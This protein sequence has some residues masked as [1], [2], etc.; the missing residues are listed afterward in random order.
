MKQIKKAASVILLIVLMYI[1]APSL[2]LAANEGDN[3]Q[4][5]N[6]TNSV[7]NL[8]EDFEM[9]LE[10]YEVLRELSVDERNS[11]GSS[12][13]TQLQSMQILQNHLRSLSEGRLFTI[14]ARRRFEANL[15]I[16]SG[17]TQNTTLTE[18]IHGQANTP[19]NN[20]RISFAGNGADHGCGPIAVHNLLYSLYTAGIT[21]Q[22]PCIAEI[23]HRLEITG[24]FIMGGELGTNPLTIKQLL[25]ELGHGSHISFLPENIDRN[26]KKSTA[27]TAI[28]LYIGQT[29][30]DKAYWHYIM[31]RHENELFEL[32]NVGGRDRSFRTVLSVDEWT[33]SRIP[34]A[35]ITINYATHQ[36]E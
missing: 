12:M 26:I 9:I 19:Q 32:Y 10:F 30:S 35:L 8:I 16:S 2:V 17:E 33:K 20:L 13:M 21:D 31:I 18:F 5:E 28:L 27:T 7:R 6:L 4:N 14:D 24:A 1:F 34:L 11:V 29:R 15:R 3:T 36:A 25:I 22:A 23:I